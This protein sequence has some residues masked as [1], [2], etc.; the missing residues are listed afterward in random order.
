[1]FSGIQ[2]LSCSLGIRLRGF[3]LS[4]GAPSFVVAAVALPAAEVPWASLEA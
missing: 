4:A 1:M 2:G 3:E